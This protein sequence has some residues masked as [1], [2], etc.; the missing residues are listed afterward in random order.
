MN[1]RK[2]G[3]NDVSILGFGCM[4]FP[5]K[6]NK[7]DKEKTMGLLKEAY[8]R[9]ITYFDTAWPYHNGES[10]IVLG[11]FLK[12]ID[13]SSV[14]VADKMPIWEINEYDDL[15]QYFIAQ[16]EKM[17]LDYFDYYLLHA[18]NKEE[19]CRIKNIGMVDWLLKKKEEGK[20]KNIGFS[21]HDEYSVFE[22]MIDLC[23]WDFAQIQLNYI[24]ENYQAGIR[25]LRYAE[26]KGIDIVVME[27]LR[28][29]V[30]AKLDKKSILTTLTLKHLLILNYI[31][32]QYILIL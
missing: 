25:G 1:K 14:F 19:L 28:G 18:V 21:F 26:V 11:E 9:G 2:L 24:D 31:F 15:D 16:L 32:H 4:R 6:D 30:L 5:I 12:T 23:D 7:I 29:G 22:E 20:I 13:R 8:D 27:P 3:C 17:E 10:E